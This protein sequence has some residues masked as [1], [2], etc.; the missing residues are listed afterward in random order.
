V[1]LYG[2]NVMDVKM[3][4]VGQLLILILVNYVLFF[5][6]KNVHIIIKVVLIVLLD[7]F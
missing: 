1:D 2:I 5:I 7:I 4:M 3:V 6:V